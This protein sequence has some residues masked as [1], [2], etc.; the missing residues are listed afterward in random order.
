MIINIKLKNIR[1]TIGLIL[2]VLWMIIVFML[3]G[4]TGTDSANTSG[5][6]INWLLEMILENENDIQHIC[7]VG[8]L[9]FIIRKTAHFILYIIGGGL[10]FN[11]IYEYKE[12]NKYNKYS[13]ITIGVLYAITDELHQYFIPG[14][15]AEIRDVFIDSAGILLGV[16]LTVSFKL[17]KDR[18]KK[19]EKEC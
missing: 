3:S 10:I 2:V 19:V 12:K 14:R 7:I 18:M 4:Q 11:F 9:Q 16:F 13:A 17:L 8:Q 1:I 5:S 6:F 15:S